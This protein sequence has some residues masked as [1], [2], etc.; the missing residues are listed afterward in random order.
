MNAESDSA[1]SNISTRSDFLEAARSVLLQAEQG[2]TRAITLIDTDFSPWPLDDEPIVHALTRWIRRPGRRLRLVGNRFDVVQRDQPRFAAW[3][4]P[5][6]HAIEALRPTEVEPAD[7]P[8]VLLLDAQCL[9][10]LDRERWLARLTNQ[11]RALVLQRE[12]LDALMQ[13]CEVAWPVTVLGL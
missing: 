3:R 13:R 9:E 4:A 7:M 5:F 6:A 10:L 8:S 1:P 12:R 11:R 2:G